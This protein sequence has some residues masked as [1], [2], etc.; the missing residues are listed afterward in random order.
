M[1]ATIIVAIAVTIIEMDPID[2]P[3]IGNHTW[4]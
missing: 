3:L 1:F 4:I 2:G